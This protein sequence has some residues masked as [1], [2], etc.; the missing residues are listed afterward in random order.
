[1]TGAVGCSGQCEGPLDKMVACR[2]SAC[3]CICERERKQKCDIAKLYPR[4][5][6][7]LF[8]ATSQTFHTMRSV[9]LLALA[10][11]ALSTGAQ[12]RVLNTFNCGLTGEGEREGGKTGRHGW[13]P[14]SARV[15]FFFPPTLRAFITHPP[16]HAPPPPSPATHPPR[17]SR[18]SLM[19]SWRCVLVEGCLGIVCFSRRE[20]CA[21]FF[22]SPIYAPCCI[23]RV[24]KKQP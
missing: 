3:K 2:P 12:V 19:T 10:G 20:M 6:K 7:L 22:A 17:P 5:F 23:R 16:P 11:L 14:A 13:S 24:A 21:L 15:L 4:L 8:F 1:M 9:I 18:A